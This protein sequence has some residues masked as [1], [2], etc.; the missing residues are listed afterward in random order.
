[1]MPPAPTTIENDGGSPP[2]RISDRPE[3]A[4]GRRHPAGL[5]RDPRSDDDYP[6]SDGKGQV[7]VPEPERVG[8]TL[9][10]WMQDVD[11]RPRRE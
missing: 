5:Q 11:L 6:D 7:T 2:R 8:C 4:Q 3:A 1:M 9:G 10:E